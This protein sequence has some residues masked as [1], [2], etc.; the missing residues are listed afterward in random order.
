[1][2]TPASACAA[3]RTWGVVRRMAFSR[4][5]YQE[6]PQAFACFPFARLVAT[7]DKAS[8]A[9]WVPVV[10]SSLRAVLPSCFCHRSFFVASRQ[11][12]SRTLYSSRFPPVSGTPAKA[13]PPAHLCTS[14]ASIARSCS[15]ATHLFLQEAGSAQIA[16]P[17][18]ESCEEPCTPFSA[19]APAVV[20]AAET[21]VPLVPPLLSA[22]SQL[23]I[24]FHSVHAKEK[25]EPR[26]VLSAGDGLLAR[27]LFAKIVRSTVL[28]GSH[29]RS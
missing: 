19:A 20:P 28:L 4:C 18:L 7:E 11:T 12:A 8:L 10:P 1:M 3:L 9:E 14:R 21:A 6:Q 26:M 16:V 27:V 17:S 24:L 15:S 2:G 23:R 22:L 25:E 13:H 5:T 29:H